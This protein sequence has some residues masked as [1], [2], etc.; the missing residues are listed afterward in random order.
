MQ[1]KFTSK[2]CLINEFRS[3]I[4]VYATDASHNS[5]VL[6][7]SDMLLTSNEMFRKKFNFKILIAS[8]YSQ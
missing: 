7:S 2:S 8:V 6:T 4:R 5:L 3:F 1:L